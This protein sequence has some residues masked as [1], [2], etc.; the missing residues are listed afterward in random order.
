[1]LLLWGGLQSDWL[2]T[3]FPALTIH[4]VNFWIGSAKNILLL[5]GVWLFI[6]VML[7][8]WSY[9]KTKIFK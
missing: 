8:T 1:M 2:T 5:G 3:Q 9:Y 7:I 4:D 6:D